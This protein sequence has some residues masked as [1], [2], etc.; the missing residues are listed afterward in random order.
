M[1]KAL[2]KAGKTGVKRVI[3]GDDLIVALAK[4]FGEADLFTKI[5]HVSFSARSA[6]KMMI[7]ESLPGIIAL[8]NA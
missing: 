1:G 2:I 8:Q 7:G 6:M 4:S 5:D 3:V